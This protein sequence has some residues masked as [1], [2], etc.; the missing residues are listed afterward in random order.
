MLSLARENVEL[1]FDEVNHK[2]AASFQK[3]EQNEEYIDYLNM[4]ITRYVAKVSP[5]DMPEH[6]SE[7]LSALFKVTGNI[8]RISDHAVNLSEYVS[9]LLSKGAYFSSAALEEARRMQTLILRSFDAIG[10]FQEK[11]QNRL[12]L[13]ERYEQDIDEL[14]LLFRE[15]QIKRMKQGACDAAASVIY[16]EMLTDMERMS[17]HLLNI[18]EELSGKEFEQQ[19]VSTTVAQ[20]IP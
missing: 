15:N 8:E 1:A 4:E 12:G 6:D 18:D 20:L 11:G 10:G 14:T 13:V 9:L 19:D 2:S 17:D 7:T 5:A 16:T 3:I